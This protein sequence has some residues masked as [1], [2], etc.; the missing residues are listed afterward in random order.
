M[1]QF[2][3]NDKKDL[4]SVLPLCKLL[5]QLTNHINLQSCYTGINIHKIAKK[6]YSINNNIALS[7]F[8]QSIDDNKTLI[9][10]METGASLAQPT[11]KMAQ[12]FKYH[13]VYGESF[14]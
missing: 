4:I 13:F 2:D 1:N 14:C 3:T 11:K 5:S 7:G 9:E 10:W 12:D 8:D 6:C